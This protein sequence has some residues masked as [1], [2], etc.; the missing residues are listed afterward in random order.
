M[1]VGM[2]LAQGKDFCVTLTLEDFAKNLKSLLTSPE[3]WAGR[4]EP[5]SLDE[6]RMRQC[7]VGEPD[8]WA[9]DQISALGWRGLPQ[10]ST[11]SVGVMCSVLTKWFGLRRGGNRRRC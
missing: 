9:L 4:K 7:K 11:R 2:G 1:Q 8:I 6:T 5:A 3:L 10:G